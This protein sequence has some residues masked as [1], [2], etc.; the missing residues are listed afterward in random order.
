MQTVCCKNDYSY[1]LSNNYTKIINISSILKHNDLIKIYSSD[2]IPI[3]FNTSW[4]GNL[5]K[6]IYKKNILIPPIDLLSLSSNNIDINSINCLCQDNTRLMKLPQIKCEINN[7][8]YVFKKWNGYN[9]LWSA[10]CINNDC[11]GHATLYFLQDSAIFMCSI[12]KNDDKLSD[13]LDCDFMSISNYN[14]TSRDEFN[15]IECS[16]LNLCF[17]NIGLLQIPVDKKIELINITNQ[18]I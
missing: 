17:D 18:E 11:I 10:Y 4:G 12:T 7:E 16:D 1:A 5:D 2:T 13:Y 14:N 6:Q 15:R 3:V 9:Q 8:T